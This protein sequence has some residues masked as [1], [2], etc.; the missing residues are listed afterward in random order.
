MCFGSSVWWVCVFVQNLPGSVQE[1][2]ASL[3]VCLAWCLECF[4]GECVCVVVSSPLPCVC[5]VECVSASLW[6]VCSVELH[7]CWRGCVSALN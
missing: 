7:V 3:A 6:G 5:V 2:E 1:G 4:A